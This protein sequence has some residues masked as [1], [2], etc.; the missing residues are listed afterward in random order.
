MVDLY[1]QTEKVTGVSSICP[2]PASNPPNLDDETLV[3]RI[4]SEFQEKNLLVGFKP[5]FLSPG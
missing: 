3:Q 2:T 1:T 5:A 4:T